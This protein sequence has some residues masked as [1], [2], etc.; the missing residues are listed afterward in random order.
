[1]V[2]HTFL[3]GSMLEA[4]MCTFFTVCS[5]VVYDLVL[6]FLFI[7]TKEY[8]LFINGNCMWSVFLLGRSAA[9][10][11]HFLLCSF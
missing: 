7:H 1:V 5:H 3:Q 10:S 2:S 4:F 11:F 8:I 6:R 9:L